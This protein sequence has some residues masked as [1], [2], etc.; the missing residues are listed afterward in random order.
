MVKRSLITYIPIWDA[1]LH[2]S[3]T[4]QPGGS[5]STFVVIPVWVGHKKR[6]K[7][8]VPTTAVLMSRTMLEDIY[9]CFLVANNIPSWVERLTY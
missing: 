3:P 7:V 8:T 1:D 4:F 6:V 9:R 5:L 2:I